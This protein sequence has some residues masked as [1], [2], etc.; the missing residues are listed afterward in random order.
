MKFKLLSNLDSMYRQVRIYA[1]VFA[2]F[3]LAVTGYSIYSSYVFAREQRE[4]IYVLDQGKSLML[5]LS[6][7]A[8]QNRPVE[9]REHVR[10]FHELLFTLSPEKAAIESNVNRA[11]SLADESGYKVYKDLLEQGYYNRIISS[12]ATQRIEIDS[13]LTDFDHYPYRVK[14]Y[15]KLRI[16]RSSNMTVRSLVT[17]QELRNTVRSDNNPQGLMIEHFTILE[18]KELEIIKR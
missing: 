4:K 16:I 11:L 5:A 3:C 6:Q 18:N 13:L 8:A 17:S 7:D 12:N 1:I 15:G 9:I 2:L 10:R 14:L